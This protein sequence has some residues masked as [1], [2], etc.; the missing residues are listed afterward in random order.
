MATGDELVRPGAPTGP[1]QIY[2]SSVYGL[3]A[4]IGEW[5]GQPIDLGIAKD[6]KASLLRMAEGARGADLFV[7][8]GGASVGDHDLVQ[9]V[10]GEAG[11]KIDFWK[12]AMRPGKPLMFGRLGSVPMVGLPGNP[13]SAL[14]C[15]VLFLKP[16]IDALLGL[17]VH[18]P[19]RASVTI[20]S[21]LPANDSREDYLRASLTRENGKLVATPFSLQ[22]S[23]MLSA[24]ATAECL[25]VRTAN[26]P[27]ARSGDLGE[28]IPLTPRAL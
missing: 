27:A 18:P 17:P 2:A 13:V 21:D 23:S 24:L 3:S 16:S 1:A 9:S 8:L 10:L 28:A 4:L 11:L 26:A 7:T 22:D 6:D 20:G 15:S 12:I 14:V 5:G 19:H 25:L